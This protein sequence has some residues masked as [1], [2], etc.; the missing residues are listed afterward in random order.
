ML[1][2]VWIK[3]IYSG[4]AILIEPKL[5][6]NKVINMFFQVDILHSWDII[7]WYF[8]QIYHVWEG[9]LRKIPVERWK[10]SQADSKGNLV[11]RLI[12]F[13]NTPHNMIYLFNYTEYYLEH[14]F[15][16]FVTWQLLNTIGH[17]ELFP[18]AG[19]VVVFRFV[20]SDSGWSIPNE[21]GG[22]RLARVKKWNTFSQIPWHR[23]KKV[24]SF[25]SE[26]FRLSN[27]INHVTLRIKVKK[28]YSEW[29]WRFEAR[30]GKKVKYVFANTVAQRG[31]KVKSSCKIPRQQ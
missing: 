30:E 19:T 6:M 28:K 18:S 16:L 24:K 27:L 9:Y 11:S 12:F 26:H 15:F 14:W 21:F 4:T 23:G 22:L 31:V 1:D 5:W 17:F 8:E 7:S 25:T 13:A 20:M 29:I 10:I 3:L 2:P